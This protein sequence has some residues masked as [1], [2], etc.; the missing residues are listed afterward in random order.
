MNYYITGDCHGDFK[1]VHF[2][3]EHNKTTKD[4]ILIILGDAGLNYWMNKSDENSK[5]KLEELPISFLMIHGNHEERPYNIPTYKEREWHGGVVYYEEKYPSLLFAKDGEV[6]DLGGKKGIAIGGAYSV[7]KNYRCMVGI[8][9][10]SDEQPSVQI[11]ETVERQLEC[12]DWKVDYIF[13]HT[14]PCLVMPRDLFLN[15]VDQRIVDN[16]TEEWLDTIC[17]KTNFERWYFGHFHDNRIT[18]SFTMLYEAI[19]ELDGKLMQLVGNSK[20]GKGQMVLFKSNEGEEIPGRIE[21]IYEYGTL[22]QSK[23]VSYGIM[24]IDGQAYE[25]IVESCIELV[26]RER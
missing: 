18:G 7:D 19:Y 4:D 8:P 26:Q 21:I 12:L 22:E 9:W 15:F 5:K 6:Y 20:Y 25:G 13:S 14:C 3:C 2:F 23:E 11:K 16:S 24:G 10:F 1:K 17:S